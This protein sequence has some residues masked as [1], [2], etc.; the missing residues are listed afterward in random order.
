MIAAGVT[1]DFG[2]LACDSADY[3]LETLGITFETAKL[4]I[5]ST[6]QAAMT[7]V[8]TPL[9]FSSLDKDKLRQT[10]EGACLYLKTYLQF[11]KPHVQESLKEITDDVDHQ[12]PNLCVFFM[13]LH[14]G[15]PTVAQFNSFLDFAPR[16]LWSDN[17]LKF[18]TVLFGDDSKPEKNEI[19]KQ[20]TKFME[21]EA[22]F[23]ETVTP[24]IVGEIL[25]RGIYKKA[26]L[27]M[28]IGTKQKYAGGVVNVAKVDKQGVTP[29]SGFLV[30]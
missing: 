17:G 23:Y 13:G 19:F 28:T 14:K 1:K 2:V 5:V 30:L 29:M 25:T 8:G 21:D 7:Y 6:G 16:Y 22:K 20:S 26:D 3:D 15:F 9:Y 24:G 4:G 12:Q 10:F 18:S 11:M 27:E